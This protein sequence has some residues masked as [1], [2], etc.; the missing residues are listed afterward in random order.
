MGRAGK[1]SRN[2]TYAW[3]LGQVNVS[4]TR[5]HAK[6]GEGGGGMNLK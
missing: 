5:T 4:N 1:T 6:I 2:I 3:T